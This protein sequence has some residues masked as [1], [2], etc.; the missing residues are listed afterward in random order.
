[1]G[2]DVKK[3]RL[4][5]VNFAQSVIAEEFPYPVSIVEERETA[6]YRMPQVS[7]HNIPP[8][9]GGQ[10]TVTIAGRGR[11]HAGK[12][13]YDLT[14]GTAF[15]YRDCDPSVSYRFPEDSA[16][17]WHFI[18]INFMGKGS[19]KTIAEINRQYGYFFDL[20]ED[21]ALLKEL[22][23]YKKYANRTF[24]QTPLEGA[25]MTFE[26]LNLLCRSRDN[27]IRESGKKRLIQEV[28]MEIHRNFDEPLTV[29]ALADA[30]GVH[31]THL[32]TLFH[33]EM[34]CTVQEYLI[35]QRLAKAMTLLIKS[36]LTCKDICRI[37]SFGSYSSFFRAFQKKY[38]MSPEIF[39]QKK[40]P[41]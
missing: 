8:E 2:I 40:N 29:S 4:W 21:D 19:E 39:R 6:G 3:V 24:F 32:S 41:Q 27:R 36:D 5:S 34:G 25:K 9:T 37:C 20:S 35:E 28:L 22:L 14:P 17:P 16:E 1:M 13:R 33:A 18:W 31:R 38:N 10:I 26:M 23:S 7:P 30:A 15:L 12:E 11:L